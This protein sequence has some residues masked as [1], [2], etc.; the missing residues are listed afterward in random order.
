MYS[1]SERE[2][3]RLTQWFNASQ[4]DETGR[5]TRTHLEELGVGD[6][7]DDRDNVVDDDNDGGG[8]DDDCGCDSDWQEAEVAPL[9]HEET[10]ALR[11]L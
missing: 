11:L 2:T 1:V 6:E 10:E 7:D 5:Q 9:P 4:T 3:A 8:G